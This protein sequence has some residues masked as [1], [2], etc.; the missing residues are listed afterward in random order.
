MGLDI[1]ALEKVRLISNNFEA[2]ESE[3]EY[4]GENEI[5]R[6]KVNSSFKSHDHLESGIYAYEG[7]ML[8]FSAG[9]YGTYNGFRAELCFM[10]HGVLPAVVWK[11][12]EMYEKGDFYEIINFSDCEGVIGPFVASK[13]LYDFKKHRDT[14]HLENNTW[15][16]ER[17]DDWI[18]ALELASNDGMLI[19]C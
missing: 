17:Y 10:A 6:V 5:F 9:S 18:K 1:V 7:K 19:F 13:L 16:A 3:I 11:N 12:P 14:Y 15:D 8:D 4:E 2:E